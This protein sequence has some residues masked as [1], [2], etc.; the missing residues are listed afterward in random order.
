MT[1]AFS[2]I[3]LFLLF[4]PGIIFRINYYTSVF[5]KVN[6]K[7]RVV[8][9]IVWSSVHALL[10]HLFGLLLVRNILGYSPDIRLLGH[11]L[12]GTTDIGIKNEIFQNIKDFKYEIILYN[13]W[14]NFIPIPI[15]NLCRE[16]VRISGM[17][18]RFR[19]FRFPN[20]YFYI[21]SGEALQFIQATNRLST[22]YLIDTAVVDVLT[23]LDGEK[24]IY[25]GVLHNYYTNTNTELDCILLE[26]VMKSKFVV[27]DDHQYEFEELPT[28][29]LIIPYSTVLNLNL[30]FYTIEAPNHQQNIATYR[31]YLLIQDQ[32]AYLQSIFVYLIAAIA[33]TLVVYAI[34]TQSWLALC[35]YVFIALI[36]LIFF[37]LKIADNFYQTQARYV[38]DTIMQSD[39]PTVKYKLI[40]K[41]SL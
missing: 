38:I 35:H 3:L 17:D 1:I 39:D 30:R 4:T 8:D 23:D 6:L 12:S 29:Q 16:L 40:N 24:V 19:R 26:D 22:K 11:L 33:G 21:L 10:F 18:I 2:T 41:F 7:T 27:E 9:E 34:Y 28:S 31:K 37:G 20:R 14:I 13:L 5:S 32:L 36:V 15:G 25:T